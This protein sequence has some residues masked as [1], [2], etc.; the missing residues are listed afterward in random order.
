M[1]PPLSL[2]EARALI[3]TEIDDYLALEAPAHMLLI[4]AVPGVG[5]TTAAVETAEACAAKGWRVA[6]SGPRHDFFTDVTAIARRP[7][8]WYEW[9]PRHE[10][11]GNM[12]KTCDWTPQINQWL[13]K[14]YEGIDFCARVCGWDYI[15]ETCRWH[16]QKTRPE[17]IIFIQHQ[18]VASGHPLDFRVLIGDENPLQAF[19][20]RWDIP[21]G[22]VLPHG[23]DYTE[24]LYEVLLKLS[25]L[26]NG[27]LTSGP[28][29]MDALGGAQEVLEACETF[30]MPAD[31]LAQADIHS[32]WEAERADYFHLPQLVPLLAREARAAADDRLYPPRIIAGKGD[33]TLL[34]RRQPANRWP[35]HVI[36][37]DATGNEHIYAE[38]FG[39]QVKVVDAAPKL[40]GSVTVVTDRTNGKGDFKSDQAAALVRKVVADG[41]FEHP[42]VVTFQG[43]EAEIAGE[44]TSA[45]FYGARGTNRLERA[46]ALF[47]V[48][49][50]MPAQPVIQTMAAMLYFNRMM[51]F[52]QNWTSQYVAY[53]YTGPDGLGREYPAGGW[54]ADPDLQALLWQLREAEILQAVHRARPVHR[55][56]PIYLLSNL[57]VPEL[58]VARLVTAAE[59]LGAPMGVNSWDWQRFI[60][61]VNGR[62]TVTANEIQIG[63]GVAIN[64]AI[65]YRDALAQQP[66]WE[67]A[68]HRTSRGQMS[69]AASRT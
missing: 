39:R 62:G 31:A 24:P 42:A 33:L 19:L 48:G 4:R 15:N 37:L 43:A 25:G 14:G 16:K 21:A 9:L 49:A 32:A 65:K 57:P 29:L 3:R 30:T 51:R 64:T 44:W 55:V 69:K 1:R 40:A 50:P 60:E 68:A 59:L 52:G 12:P 66:G 7:E 11:D 63:L 18:H 17:P 20:R 53:Q 8:L 26:C 61:W 47:V 41:G 23:V 58:P 2:D 22:Q 54:W 36:W 10:G 67:L 34:L 28:E 35:P 6:Y 27:E 45:H 46:D 38:L 13:M 5:K 56:V